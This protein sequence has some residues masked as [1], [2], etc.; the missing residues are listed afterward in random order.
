MRM[1]KYLLILLTFTLQSA[2]AQNIYYV[3]NVKGNVRLE[4]TKTPLRVNDQI[5]GQDALIFGS[6]NDVVAVI[7]TKTGRMILRP[8]PSAKSS[9]LV[10]VVSD[11]L[12]P[13]TARL[14]TRGGG[15]TNIVELEN[16]FGADT[17][18]V[19]GTNKV[20]I[21]PS[22]FP[23]NEANFFFVRYTYK[24]ETINKKLNFE[25]DSL[26]LS[27]SE[28]Y[29]ID[30]APINARDVSDAT[31]FY[32]QGASAS[33]KSA[34]SVS[35]PNEALV[36]QALLTFKTRSGLKGN[37]LLDELTPLL[38]DM[39]GRTDKNNVSNWARKNLNP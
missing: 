36:K 6:P 30:N 17:L 33:E 20:W 25:K 2:Y 18:Y 9:E 19:L 38:R 5:S 28:L 34:F 37:K 23:M 8:K 31:L 21:S 15:V 10:S 35:F 11:I 1:L 26:I 3:L 24:G 27:A 7:S 32:K 39:Y 12:N 22:A 13:G 4:K 16:Y 29:K 14:S